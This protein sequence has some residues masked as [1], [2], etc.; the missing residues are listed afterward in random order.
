MHNLF[1]KLKSFI[2]FDWRD[3]RE[4]RRK[5]FN[6]ILYDDVMTTGNHMTVRVWNVRLAE[7]MDKQAC[8]RYTLFCSRRCCCSCC[9]CYQFAR[10]TRWISDWPMNIFASHIFLLLFLSPSDDWLTA[11]S[12]NNS[13]FVAS[14]P[15]H[16]LKT[17]EYDKRCFKRQELIFISFERQ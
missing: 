15:E 14:F 16:E 13:N 3:G 2:K 10:G 5:M 8:G 6:N 9:C 7:W 12:D 11:L 17:N 1:V 4:E